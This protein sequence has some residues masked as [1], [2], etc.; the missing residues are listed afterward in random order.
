MVKQKQTVFEKRVSEIWIVTLGLSRIA[1]RSNNPICSKN[2]VCFRNLN[3]TRNPRIPPNICIYWLLQTSNRKNQS[4]ESSKMV[5]V[6]ILRIPLK[7][8]LPPVRLPPIS[9]TLHINRILDWI[10]TKEID[11]QLKCSSEIKNNLDKWQNLDYND[12][13]LNLLFLISCFTCDSNGKNISVFGST[14]EEQ[15]RIPCSHLF[16]LSACA[17]RWQSLLSHHL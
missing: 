14:S 4:F 6:N 16:C 5:G 12:G 13:S 17:N 10:K 15:I 9:Y 7:K 11:V 1:P 3:E 8:I 2:S